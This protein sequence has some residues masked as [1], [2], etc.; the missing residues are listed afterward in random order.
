MKFQIARFAEKNAGVVRTMRQELNI[1]QSEKEKNI[2]SIPKIVLT[3]GKKQR[4][5]LPNLILIN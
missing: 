2:F 3:N 4:K 5:T 1:N